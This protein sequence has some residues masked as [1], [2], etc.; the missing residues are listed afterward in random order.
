LF[1]VGNTWPAQN[2]RVAGGEGGGDVDGQRLVVAA[3]DGDRW[4][5]AEQIDRLGGLADGLGSHPG[6]APLQREVLPQQQAMS[7]GGLV[8]L[9]ATDVAVDA[10]QVQ[11]GLAGQDDVGFDLLR[12]GVAQF[13]PGRSL[14]GPFQ[15]QPLAV[16]GGDEVLHPELAQ[17][18]C[19]PPAIAH[20][21]TAGIGHLDRHLVQRL[22]AQRV[23]PPQSGLVDHHLPPHVVEP[24]GERVLDLARRCGRGD[25][26]G[27]GGDAAGGRVEHRP[28][29]DDGP[30]RARFGAQHS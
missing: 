20:H 15:V 23:G 17:P 7:V 21:V 5:V 13:P 1:Q 24:G 28:D 16:H 6:V 8:Q 30:L 3:P 25:G 29:L 19:H 22:I 4:V 9:G 11:P 27:D 2:R 10:Q 26:G 18:G 14:V 12:R